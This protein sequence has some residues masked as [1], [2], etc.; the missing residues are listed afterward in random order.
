MP[1]FGVGM[2]SKKWCSTTITKSQELAQTMT[3]L[4]ETTILINPIQ[5]AQHNLKPSKQIHSLA[6]GNNFDKSRFPQGIV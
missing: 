2:A 6:C 3:K 4:Y 1:N 5:H